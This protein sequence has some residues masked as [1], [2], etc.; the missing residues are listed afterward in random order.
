M[1][2]LL[3]DDHPL[4]RDGL[5]QLL[6]RIWPEATCTALGSI[7][8]AI[9]HF[10]AGEFF[11]LILLD[12]L[13]PGQ[14]GISA[15]ELLREKQ[16]VPI[17][18]ISSN[19]SPEVVLRCIDMGAM[20][21]IPKTASSA[22]MQAA[23]QIVQ[24]GGIYV[25]PS[26]IVASVPNL[27]R[28]MPPRSLTHPVD[29]GLSARQSDVLKLLLEGKS[30]KEICRDLGLAPATVKTH[31]S[32]VLRVLDVTTRTQAVLMASRIGLRF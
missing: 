27:G 25:P 31:V 23:L 16:N 12:L 9:T 4:F 3:I 20:G 10:D 15:L 13:L 19:D 14:D 8:E 29:I 1:K 21:F 32:A 17:V 6:L 24:A 18:C 26:A 22:V 11:N 28:R 30:N 2:I 7:R 5:E